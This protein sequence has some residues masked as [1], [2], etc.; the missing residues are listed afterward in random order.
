[1]PAAAERVEPP[2]HAGG[3]DTEVDRRLASRLCGKR[4]KKQAAEQCL[5]YLNNFSY[6]LSLAIEHVF[7]FSPFPAK[8]QALE[9]LENF[10]IRKVEQA[11]GVRSSL[12]SRE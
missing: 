5:K 8:I 6:F 11:A 7:N 12:T 4:Q 10:L 3:D 1:M 2:T 9:F